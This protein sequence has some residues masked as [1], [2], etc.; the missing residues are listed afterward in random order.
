MTRTKEVRREAPRSEA[1]PRRE[2]MV[3]IPEEALEEI[4]TRFDPDYG[5][6]LKRKRLY[7]RGFRQYPHLPKLAMEWFQEIANEVSQLGEELWFSKRRPGE[8]FREG[9]P[10]Y[11]YHEDTL[12]APPL[13]EIYRVKVGDH[14]THLMWR[15]KERTPEGYKRM[16]IKDEFFGVDMAILG[17]LAVT[18]ADRAEPKKSWEYVGDEPELDFPEALLR[19]YRDDFD[20]LD[21]DDQKALKIDTYSRIHDSLES[22]RLLMAYLEYGEP[23]KG[24]TTKPLTTF[25]RDVRAA[26]LKRVEGLK[27]HEIAERLVAEGLGLEEPKSFRDE[28]EKKEKLARKARDSAKRG[29]EKYLKEALGEKKLRHHIRRSQAEMKHFEQLDEVERLMWR[30]ADKSHHVAW[31]VVHKLR[32]GDPN[33][34]RRDRLKEVLSGLLDGDEDAA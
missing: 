26:E 8:A 17:V 25:R 10:P 4:L 21:P 18:E 6:N 11:V 15:G 30:L 7:E 27:N 14:Q 28:D 1:G 22:L 5:M 9:L 19:Y 12:E 20:D 2:Y 24:V 13:D 31:S 16:V 3:D 29:E 33:R 34:P 32:P 23:V